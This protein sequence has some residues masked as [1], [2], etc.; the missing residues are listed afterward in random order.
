MGGE[1]AHQAFCLQ[2]P[3]AGEAPPQHLPASLAHPASPLA[4]E[5]EPWA[6]SF[7]LAASARRLAMALTSLFSLPNRLCE[8][9]GSVNV[10]K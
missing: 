10:C 2:K 8:G 6:S 7:T 1:Q 5:G 3:H 4:P 9:V